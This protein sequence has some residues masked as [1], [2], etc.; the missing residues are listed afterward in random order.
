MSIHEECGVFGIYDPAGDCARTTYYGLYSLQHRGQE[1][2]G[3]ATIND[4]ELSYHKDLGLVGDVFHQDVLDRLGGTMAVGHVRYSTTGGVRRENAQPLTLKYVK[5]TLAVAH[6]GNLVNTPELRTSFE[7]RGAIFQTTTDSEL[8][9]YAIAQERLRC[10]SAEEAVC[11]AVKGLRGAFSL[12]VMSARKLIAAR[13]PWG[14]RPLCMG[15][16]GQAVVFASESCALDAVGA[17]FEREIDPGEIVVV[18]DGQVRSI[19]ENCAGATSHM[20][21]FEYIYFARPDSVICGQSVHEARLEAGR[22]LAREHPVDADVVIGVPDSGLDAAMGYAEESGIPYGQGFV[23]NRYI[24]RTFITPDQQSR[25]QAVRIKLGA[26][27]STVEGRRVVMID[28]SIVRGTTS[29]QIISLLREAGAKEV[30][31]R[32]SAPPFIAPCYFGTDIPDK[33]D[34]IACRHTVEEIRRLVGADTLGFL[35]VDAL[36]RI[37]PSAACGFCKGCFTEEYPVATAGM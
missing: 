29:R 6:N 25:E 36:E 14:F 24:G 34:L 13:D 30:H 19:R 21:I 22:I 28:D 11:Q 20:C 1:A 31:F 27:R 12:I 7:Y 10:G 18:E 9:A 3:I 4:R 15:R 8:I 5:G 26:L 35:S 23:K 2:C 37:A 16:R 33:K 32:V 17:A